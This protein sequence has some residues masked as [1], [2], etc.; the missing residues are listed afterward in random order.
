MRARYSAWLCAAF[1]TRSSERTAGAPTAARSALCTR[2]I[3]LA[4]FASEV[5]VALGVGATDGLAD[6][7]ADTAAGLAVGVAVSLAGG[8]AATVGVGVNDATLTESCVDR[9][10]AIARPTASTTTSAKGKRVTAVA[11][12]RMTR[13]YG[14]LTV[15]TV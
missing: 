1:V 11:M 15:T 10:P 6:G 9:R 2:S 7:L 14:F 8:T 3:S 13:R 4:S 5:A 12:R